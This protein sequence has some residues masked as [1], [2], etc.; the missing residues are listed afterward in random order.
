MPKLRGRVLANYQSGGGHQRQKQ[1]EEGALAIFSRAP[2][3]DLKIDGAALI[4]K[5]FTREYGKL[6]ADYIHNMYR[7]KTPH[8]KSHRIWRCDLMAAN[9]LIS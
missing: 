5:A 8:K 2:P 6:N 1:V 3:N 4:Q 9:C 7:S